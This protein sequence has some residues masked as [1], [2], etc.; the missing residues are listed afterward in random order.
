MLLNAI[1]AT[2]AFFWA[3]QWAPDALPGGEWTVFLTFWLSIIIHM[4][5]SLVRLPI[6]PPRA[7]IGGAPLR[8]SRRT[9]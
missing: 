2:A 6:P 7:S 5:C 8:R 1:L 3:L 9:G 4:P